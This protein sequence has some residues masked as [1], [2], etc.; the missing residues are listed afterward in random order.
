MAKRPPEHYTVGMVRITAGVVLPLLAVLAGACRITPEE[1]S[2]IEAENELLREQIQEVRNN[3]E[4]YRDLEVK[5]DV[6]ADDGRGDD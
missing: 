5:P 4:Y 2:R 6:T 3:C 1:I